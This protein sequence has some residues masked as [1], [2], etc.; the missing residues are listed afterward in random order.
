M[1]RSEAIRE[2]GIKIFPATKFEVKIKFRIAT[3]TPKKICLF[4][5]EGEVIGSGNITIEKNRIVGFMSKT[6]N[7][8]GEKCP[9]DRIAKIV[10][11]TIN[12]M[13]EKYLF[14]R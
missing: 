1:I 9:E 12:A 14:M 10:F 5:V 7:I 3:S 6:E 8:L 4:L 11:E 2:S 13:I